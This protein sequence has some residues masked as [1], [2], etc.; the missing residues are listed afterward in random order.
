M[1][2]KYFVALVIMVLASC[3]SCNRESNLPAKEQGF[4]NIPDNNDSSGEQ[5]SLRK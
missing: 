3:A 4:T 1:K 2:T 5:S